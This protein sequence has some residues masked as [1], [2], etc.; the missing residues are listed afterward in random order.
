[1][2]RAMDVGMGAGHNETSAFFA[3]GFSFREEDA[4]EPANSMMR[5]YSAR[6][7]C[8]IAIATSTTTIS[9][10]DEVFVI[11]LVTTK[12]SVLEDFIAADRSGALDSLT[13]G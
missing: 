3:T 10:A 13:P 8:D 5:L 9:S 2:T 4:I 1:M 6:G 7:G 12:C 11:A